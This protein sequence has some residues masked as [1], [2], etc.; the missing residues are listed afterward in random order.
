[1]IVAEVFRSPMVD[2][3]LVAFGSLIPMIEVAVGRVGVLHTLLAPSVLLAAVMVGTIGRRLLRRR[4]LAIPI[5]LALHLVLDG[6]WDNASLFWW[7]LFGRSFDDIAVPESQWLPLRMVLELVAVGVGA[8]AYRRYGLDRSENRRLL[9]SQ[10]R[11]DRAFLGR[12][13][14]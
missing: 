8:W 13:P 6:S 9:M 5:G 10:G 11:L 4:L 3:R 2:Y 14:I 12:H 1:M 7:P